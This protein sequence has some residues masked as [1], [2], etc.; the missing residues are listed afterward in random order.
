MK[1]QP[2]LYFFVF[3][4]SF[5]FSV[6][7]QNLI[8]NPG[9]ESGTRA[10]ATAISTSMT[11]LRGL[12]KFDNPAAPLAA[13]VGPNL[14]LNGT[15]TTVAGY[16]A[17]DNAVRIGTGSNYS[18]T[19]GI[20]GNG[21]SGTYVNNY[22]LLVDFRIAALGDWKTFL[23]TN[24]TNSNDAD[25]WVRDTDGM[26]GV[27]A[28]GYSA[29]GAIPAV[30]HRL[31]VSV[32]NGSF[33]RI[34]IDGR[35]ICNGTSQAVNGRFS[36]DP[37]IYFMSDDNGEDG[38]MDVSTIALFDKALN[39]TEVE[40]LGRWTCDNWLNMGN[41]QQQARFGGYASAFAGSYYLFAGSDTP[42]DSYQD[43]NVSADAVA[44][45]AG[46]AA[47]TFSGKIQTF[48]QSPQ[49]QGRIIV[50][51]RNV[52]G[53]VLSSY[54][55]GNQSTSSGWVN[56]SN[57]RT[58]PALTRTIRIRLLHTK[59]NGTTCDAFYDDFSL[60][61]LISLGLQGIVLYDPVMEDKHCALQW[62]CEGAETLYAFDVER[63]TDFD[64]WESI[65]Q[66]GYK[67]GCYVYA[68]TDDAISGPLYYYRIKGIDS[69]AQ[70]IYSKVQS[71]HT[72]LISYDGPVIRIQNPAHAREELSLYTGQSGCDIEVYDAGGNLIHQALA[73]AADH[74]TL[75]FTSAGVYTLLVRYKKKSAFRKIVII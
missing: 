67:P 46:A 18:V 20:A 47:Y 63:S 72:G 1:T 51:Y 64:H 5:F 30:W 35:L 55:T 15:H 3:L 73:L 29:E 2:L 28:V 19:H 70:V 32:S 44:I 16:S 61:K 66:R 7:A 10:Y 74:T 42:L 68:C 45:D 54:D 26:I 37:K 8:T 33:F 34:Y 58:A 59:N 62:K 36:L 31:V 14:T 40:S 43:V 60:T 24:Q 75:S 69:T 23:Q 52:V 57:T 22:S 4:F 17:S 6:R 49:D 11:G 21:G 41:F 65:S 9:F 50:E 12:W 25:L 48:G 56:F 13:T 71:I 53:S 39:Q 27:G 38:L